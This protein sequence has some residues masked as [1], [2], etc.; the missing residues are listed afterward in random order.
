[1]TRV[2]TAGTARMPATAIIPSAAAT[3]RHG[4]RLL[5]TP[6]GSA[7]E[8]TAAR[9]ASV[10]C[11]AVAKRSAGSHASELAIVVART[12]D[13]LSRIVRRLAAG[14]AVTSP[15]APGPRGNS[16]ASISYSTTPRL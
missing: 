4:D 12:G 8:A 10:S 2:R 9:S 3:G 7:C 5:V 15:L 1:N 16:P 13:T 6:T 14:P 11:A